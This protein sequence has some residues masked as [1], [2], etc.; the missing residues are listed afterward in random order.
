MR[1][2]IQPEG[3]DA[4]SEDLFREVIPDGS[5]KA[6][7]RYT[8]AVDALIREQNDSLAGATDDARVRLR[9]WDLPECLQARRTFWLVWHHMRRSGCQSSACT[10]LRLEPALRRVR[11]S[12]SAACCLAEALDAIHVLHD[13]AKLHAGACPAWTVEQCVGSSCRRL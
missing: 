7:S 4:S 13:D 5:A 3:L 8:D 9:E 12:C 1:R 10:L 2:P 6:L 11:L